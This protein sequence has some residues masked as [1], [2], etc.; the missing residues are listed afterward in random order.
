MRLEMGQP[1]PPIV[2]SWLL[3]CTTA[4]QCAL[5]G[6]PHRSP[7][8]EQLEPTAGHGA[9]ASSVSGPASPV[10]AGQTGYPHVQYHFNV[11][12]P[13]LEL[14]E[15][16]LELAPL[17]LVEAPLELAPLEL[18]EPP[19]RPDTTGSQPRPQVSEDAHPRAGLW[20]ANPEVPS[21]FVHA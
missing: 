10:G 1:T 14:D 17:E 9:P 19:H 13:E 16:P 6:V 21:G 5:E 8:T 20:H 2:G 15:A 3:H 11:P 18:D 7:R 4:P 12:P